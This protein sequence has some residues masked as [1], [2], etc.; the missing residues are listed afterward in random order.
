VRVCQFRHFGI[1]HLTRISIIKDKL[2]VKV[3]FYLMLIRSGGDQLESNYFQGQLVSLRAFEPTDANPLQNMI[4]HTELSGRR[5]L[6]DGFSEWVS[7]T[8]PQVEMVINRWNEENNC[9]HLAILLPETGEIV[10]YASCSWGWDAHCPEITVVI[11]PLRQNQ[12]YG[13]ETL[14]LML[15]YLFETTPAHNVTLWMADWNTLGRHFAAKNGF[16]ESGCMRREGLRQGKYFDLIL[17]DIL[18]PE[19]KMLQG[20]L[21]HAA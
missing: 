9:L 2:K 4:N 8:L 20:G 16:R 19:W 12:G 13:S 18:R 10:G 1:F 15:R 14:N 17:T 7:L 5:Y 6:P 11:N 3:A 21:S